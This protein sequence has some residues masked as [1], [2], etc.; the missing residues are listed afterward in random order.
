MQRRTLPWQ[1]PQARASGPIVQADGRVVV[2][3]NP[4]DG[5]CTS[6]DLVELALPTAGGLTRIDVTLAAP[7]CDFDPSKHRLLPDGQAAATATCAPR[8][9]VDMSMS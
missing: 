3:S 5:S 2:L 9:Q 7:G 1:D 8:S 4:H 6:L